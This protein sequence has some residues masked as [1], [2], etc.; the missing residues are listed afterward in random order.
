M[1]AKKK[2]RAKHEVTVTPEF[3]DDPDGGDHFFMLRVN[4]KS[5][6]GFY[7]P[8]VTLRDPKKFAENAA[9][10]LRRALR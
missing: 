5:I 2:T 1:A 3:R 10:R 4:G 9:K 7:H 8:D 6:C